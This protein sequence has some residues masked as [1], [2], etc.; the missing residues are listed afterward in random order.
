[1]RDDTIRGVEDEEDIMA[2]IVY[3]LAI[4]GYSVVGFSRGEEMLAKF[5]EEGS[6]MFIFGCHASW[7]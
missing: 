3:T 5:E 2:L 6:D 1:M 7:H 4:E